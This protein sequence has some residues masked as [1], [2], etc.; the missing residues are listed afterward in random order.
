MEY[1]DSIN[2]PLLY[3]HYCQRNTNML[4]NPE[5]ISVL[6]QSEG[7]DIS[8]KIEVIHDHPYKIISNRDNAYLKKNLFK[9]NSLI[10]NQRESEF[11]LE[12]EFE[13][14]KKRKDSTSYSEMGHSSSHYME[15]KQINQELKKGVQTE[16]EKLETKLNNIENILDSDIVTQKS[17]FEERK[18]R[19]QDKIRNKPR[20]S[21]RFMVRKGS[22]LD[23]ILV[24]VGMIN[25]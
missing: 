17:S 18:K 12:N 5:V 8:V 11:W 14:D 13:Y 7:K 4:V 23:D 16:F 1:Y 2:N 3:S 15:K 25:Y 20:K 24:A 10:N 22:K 9:Q 19:K 21:H 6:D